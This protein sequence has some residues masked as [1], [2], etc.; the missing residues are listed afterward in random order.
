MKDDGKLRH[1]SDGKQWKHFNAKFSEFGDE[2][3]NV[4][5]ALSTDGMNSFGDLNSSYSTWL[6]ILTIYNLPPCLCE[7]RKYLLLTMIISRPR[8]PSN[9]ID[10]FLE[11]LMEDMQ[12]LWEDGVKMMD[13]SLKE[14]T[15]KAIIFITIT[16]YPS[17]FSLSG[18]IK[19]KLGCVVCIDGTCYTYLSASKKMV[20]MRHR[21]FLV[22]KHRYRVATMNKY[23]DNQEEPE[24]NEPERTRY[25]Q[26]VFDMVKGIYV[27]FE[28][29][30]KKEEDGTTT[31]KK[32]KRDK[33]EEPPIA[34]FL[35]R[36]SCVSSSTC[37]TRRS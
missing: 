25:G 12:I 33:M 7:K 34:P 22:K 5:F 21:R 3:R 18:Q 9:D 8:Q 13:A 2:A 4:R 24:T 11:P 16:N 35:S 10:V 37:R 30:K 31:R 6:V 19:G 20:Y 17:L 28:K 29:K 32:R 36:S 14:F 15:L 1:P 27:E 26:K 23:F